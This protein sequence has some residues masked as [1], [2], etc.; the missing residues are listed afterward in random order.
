M[1]AGD[2]IVKKVKGWELSI[3]DDLFVVSSFPGAKTDDMES[4]IKP[5]LQSKPERIIIHCGTNDVKNNTPQSI[6]D[7]ILSLT[8][9]S[10]QENNTVP[11]SSIAPGKDH[12]DKKGKEVNII[13]EKRCNKINLAFISHGNIRTRYHCNYDGL[14]LNDKGATLLTENILSTLN[15][16]A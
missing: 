6:A 15:K 3:K 7:N 12:L 5:T 2:S 14:H 8:K 11:V 4:Y 10:Q 13:L 9:S 1:V 16:A